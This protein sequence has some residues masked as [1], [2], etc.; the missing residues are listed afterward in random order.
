MQV[1]RGLAGTLIVRSKNDPIAHLPEQY[2]MTTDLHL[3][4]AAAIP[5]NT[6]MDWMLIGTDGGLLE[7]AQG[8][9]DEILLAPAE[10]VELLLILTRTG[11]APLYNR[12]YNR[13]KMMVDEVER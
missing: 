10:R 3:N 7:A 9:F 5:E 13:E 6:M 2:W 12:Y 11:K 8:P 4:T 1:A